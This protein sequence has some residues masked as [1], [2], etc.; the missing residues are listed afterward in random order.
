MKIFFGLLGLHLLVWSDLGRSRP[1]RPMRDMRINGHGPWISRHST[2]ETESPWPLHFKHSHWWKR[3]SRS[4][5]TSH[6]AWGTNRVCECKMD[7]N[8]T[9][10]PTWHQ[11]DHVPWSFGIFSKPP[12]G[13]RPST[14]PGH[15]DTPNAHNRW[16][17]LLYHVWG[18]TRIENYWSSIWLK[19]CHI[20]LHTTPE[21]PWP[22]YM[23]LEVCWDDGLWT[24][25]FGLSQFHGS[26]LVCEVALMCEVTLD[27]GVLARDSN[28]WLNAFL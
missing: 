12:L 22:H 14:K 20:W 27:T 3:R 11:M 6:Y 17:I 9:W 10:I 1:S 23:V 8:S 15:H 21:G 2:H 16:F 4:K 26:W 24:L 13:G 25:S 19:V 7:V 18:P 28:F 5:F